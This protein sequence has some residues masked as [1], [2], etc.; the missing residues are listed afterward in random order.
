MNQV[1]SNYS[2]YSKPT[3]YESIQAI[4]GA[5]EFEY[6]GAS[7][8]MSPTG[9]FI[10][11]GF[12]EADGPAIERTGLVRVYRSDGN[13]V[14][15]PFGRDGMFGSA[16]GDE[17]GTSVSISD[18]GKRVAVGARSSSMSPE[19]LKNGRASV[20]EYSAVNETWVQLGSTVQG[21]DEMDRLG[22]SVSMSGDGSRVAVGAP[23]ANGGTG[24]ATI[25]EYNGSDWIPF[26]NV[27]VSDDVGDRAGF[28][29]SLSN[30][31]NTLAVGAFTS[32]RNG[33]ARSG[34]VTVYRLEG[35]VT[36]NSSSL[37]NQ[38]Q[39]LVGAIAGAQMG[40]SVSLSDNGSRVVVGSTGFGTENTA[41]TGLCAV[42]ELQEE[43]WTQIA[44]LIGNEDSEKTGLYVSITNSG[45]AISCS[46]IINVDGAMKGAV[47]VLE[48]H[49]TGWDIVDT[50]ISSLGSST[51]FG[52]SV[53]ISQD[54]SMLLSGDPSH[55]SSAGYFEF[56]T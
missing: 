7:V 25:Y 5:K 51:S 10:A 23:R 12:K 54:G 28:S 32:S 20:F 21:V 44:T 18:D 17:F 36:E 43:N 52:A 46:K 13:N 4:R 45:N 50:V 6:A 55:N 3:S 33:L 27:I 26:D 34:S 19:K 14:Y 11:V 35:S 2:D 1:S 37:V 53:S 29:L 47:S 48:E 41:K 39:P 31:G 49:E 40:Y 30:D 9:E 16:S 22:F 38:G 8:S 15:S 56:F 24:S 42:Y